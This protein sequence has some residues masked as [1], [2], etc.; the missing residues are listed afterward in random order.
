MNHHHTDSFLP[1]DPDQ[2]VGLVFRRLSALKTE[3]GEGQALE[4]AVQAVLGALGRATHEEAE[5]RDRTLR[6]RT[7]RR[8]AGVLVSATAQRL[9]AHPWDEGEPE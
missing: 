1:Q 2:C 7:E 8:S 3:F 9:D 6:E 4:R 5:R